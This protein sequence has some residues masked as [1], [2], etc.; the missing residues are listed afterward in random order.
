MSTTLFFDSL[1]KRFGSTTAVQDFTAT[2]R[3]GAITAFLGPN[4]AGKTT[5]LRMLL[6]LVTPTAGTA[7]FDDQ[8]YDELAEPAR[9]VGALLDAT[10]FHPGRSAVNHLRIMAR[11]AG[12]AKDAPRR[13]LDAVGLTDVAE[14]NVGT[15]SLGMRQRL[16]LAG[17]LLGD[18]PV[19]VLDEPVNGLDPQGV[20]WLR[21]LLRTLADEGRTVLLS[22]HVL[23]E[24]EQTADDVLLIVGGRLIRQTSLSSLRAE[25]GVGTTV[26]SPERVRMVRLLQNAGLGVR[27]TGPDE[28]EVEGAPDLVGRLAAEHGVV[29][30]HLAERAGGLEDVFLRLTETGTRV[31]YDQLVDM[32]EPMME[33]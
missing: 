13:V 21:G 2:V 6:G 25:Y 4:G 3:P 5:T 14:R 17:A 33:H 16:G 12:I 22:S 19:L 18:P 11:A 26:R 31:A 10:G 20:R 15:F 1:T 7:R 24:I 23:H 29:L 27:T 9:E 30:H 32:P 28:L 8:R